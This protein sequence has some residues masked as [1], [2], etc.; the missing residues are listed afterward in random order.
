MS[1]KFLKALTGSNIWVQRQ[2][3]IELEELSAHFY[4]ISRLFFIL[5]SVQGGRAQAAQRAQIGP[6]TQRAQVLITTL[7]GPFG[8]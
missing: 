2:L 3:D 7:L 5:E 1:F 6:N 8:P 4:L